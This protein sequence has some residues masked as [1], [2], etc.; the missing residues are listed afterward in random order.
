M[1]FSLDKTIEIL[2]KTPDAI[3]QLTHGLSTAW[4]KTNEGENTW[5]VF[6]VVG[7]LLHGDKTDW[8]NRIKIILSES[9]DKHFEPFDRFA[10]FETSKG[11]TCEQL[12]NEF[13]TIRKEN[14][15]TLKSLNITEKDFM[16]TGIHPTFGT[17]TLQ[18]L[19][20]TWLVHDLDHIS[21]ITRIMAKQYKEETGPWIAFL[22]IINQ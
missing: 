9:G 4:I 11:K 3:S 10:Q 19:L 2:E 8:I 20:A 15:D 17:V 6:D 14:L 1:N 7:H 5:S 21:Q 16:K 12:V 18:Q 22:K 13:R